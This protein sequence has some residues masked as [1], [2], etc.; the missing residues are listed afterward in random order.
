MDFSNLSNFTQT[1]SSTGFEKLFQKKLSS[2]PSA[3]KRWLKSHSDSYIYVLVP[4]PQTLEVADG[5]RLNR[6]RL[7]IYISDKSQDELMRIAL[8]NNRRVLFTRKPDLTLTDFK[9]SKDKKEIELQ[10]PEDFFLD[11]YY[12]SQYADLFENNLL[13]A[14]KNQLNKRLKDNYGSIVK[15]KI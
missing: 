15:Q 5:T 7:L 2:K 11:C 4:K 1:Q 9:V 12:A 14:N 8:K 13:E 10:Y 3:F 6:L